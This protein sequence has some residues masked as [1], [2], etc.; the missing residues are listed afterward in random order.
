MQKGHFCEMPGIEPQTRMGDKDPCAMH[1]QQQMIAW[2]IKWTMARYDLMVYGQVNKK[3]GFH[4]K[5]E[6][7]IKTI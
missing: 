6:I 4:E 2:P 7:M 3:R 1:L 5:R